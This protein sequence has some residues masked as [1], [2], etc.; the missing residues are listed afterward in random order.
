M[1][2]CQSLV[3]QGSVLDPLLFL[4]Y[5]NDLPNGLKSNV[6]LFANDTSLFSVIY[7]ITESAN[8]LNSDLSKTD[9]WA[10]QWKMSFYS[11]PTKQAPEII[12]IQSQILTE[13]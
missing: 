4:I 10:L 1:G 2:R 5:I 3:P 11:D 9:E 12:H 6:K 8:V 7:N 13:I